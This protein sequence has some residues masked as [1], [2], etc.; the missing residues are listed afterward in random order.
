[1]N[2]SVIQIVFIVFAA[3]AL[4]KTAMQFRSRRIPLVWAVS[5]G[6]SWIVLGVVAF[7]PK[8][9]DL[10]AASVGIGRGADL[11]VYLAIVGLVYIVFRLIMK[12]QKLERDVTEIVRH[13]ALKDLDK[14]KEE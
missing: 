7:L 5:L 9:T 13:S 2:L 10:L 8:T 11:L 1:M 4:F 6:I 14:K 12:L 3:F